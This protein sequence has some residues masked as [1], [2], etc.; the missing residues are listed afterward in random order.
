MKPTTKQ[1][2]MI[3]D[4]LLANGYTTGDLSNSLHRDRG[5]VCGILNGTQALGV[6]VFRELPE[7][8]KQR[9]SFN[10]LRYSNELAHL[11]TNQRLQRVK[12]LLLSDTSIDMEEIMLIIDGY[13]D[14]E[15]K[16]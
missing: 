14:G 3:K 1:K 5:Y 6:D 12:K 15:F 13:Y 2:P 16:V 4:W 9:C 8:I 11:I 7:P 10:N